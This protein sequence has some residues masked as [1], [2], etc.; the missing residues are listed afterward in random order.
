MNTPNE[1]PRCLFTADIATIGEKQCNYCDLHD[2]LEAQARPS[3]LHHVLAKIKKHKGQYNCL[4]GVSGGLDSST[5]LYAAVKQW[6]LRPLV[7]HFDNGWNNEQATANMMNLIAKLNVNAIIY[8]LDKA[9]YDTL[10]EAFLWAGVPDADIPNDIAMTKLMYETARKHGIKYILNG[11]DFRTEG[12]TPA[13]WTYMDAKYIQSIY[14]EYTGQELKN[15]PL[16]T[17]WD[18]I[19]YGLIGIKQVR[20]FHYGFER[21]PIEAAM[22]AL[23][24]WRDYGA[25]HCEN[26]YT[27]FVGAYL[28]PVKFGIDKRIVY[29]SA[30]VRSKRILK[31]EA[32]A[33]LAKPGGFDFN[34]LGPAADRIMDKMKSRQQPRENFDRYNF[35]KW[36]LVIWFLAK[37]KRVPHTFYVKYAK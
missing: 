32:R 31:A 13:K 3:D 6:G 36:K 18:Q 23:I 25:K 28:L 17:F 8:K 30:L 35:R 33:Y 16:L 14:R 37:L 2:T 21:A 1:C 9:E 5:L 24:G 4:V 29:L 11:H 22:K 12:S 20:P 7:I 26:I 34:K 10:N 15:Y 19:F 27:E